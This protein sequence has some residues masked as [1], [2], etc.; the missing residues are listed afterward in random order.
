MYSNHG[1]Y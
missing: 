1:Y